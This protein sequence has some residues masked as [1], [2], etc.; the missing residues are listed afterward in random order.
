MFAVFA[1]L[2]GSA[3]LIGGSW[4]LNS[5]FS[6]YGARNE[7]IKFLVYA[8]I[9]ALT[10]ICIRM[11]TGSFLLMSVFTFNSPLIYNLP[12]VFIAVITLVA[13][14]TSKSPFNFSGDATIEYNGSQSGLVT[15][16]RWL[17]RTFL[18]GIIVLF[19]A[20]SFVGSAL[21]SFVVFLVWSVSNRFTGNIGP[22]TFLK[23]GSLTALL[24]I[25]INLLW[26][27][28]GGGFA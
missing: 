23:W 28:L 25:G 1:F 20:T 4:S 13:I 24:L 21:L 6:R 5:P 19:L 14:K 9:L 10:A 3:C 12:L 26:I 27:L 22:G 7:T 16:G 18:Y 17:E 15:I 8:P 2:I 11:V